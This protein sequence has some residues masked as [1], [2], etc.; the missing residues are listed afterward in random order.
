V[1]GVRFP[2]T[3]AFFLAFW[4]VVEVFWSCMVKVEVVLMIF[5]SAGYDAT[6][7]HVPARAR[8]VPRTRESTWAGLPLLYL[9]G[10]DG[11]SDR[12]AAM[13]GEDS[14]LVQKTATCQRYLQP[15][16]PARL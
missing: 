5:C 16:L 7:A 3:D 4:D 6:L 11:R 1:A 12:A 14:V 2:V 8:V 9:H 10:H 13:Q 15:L